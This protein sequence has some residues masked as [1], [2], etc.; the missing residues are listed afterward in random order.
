MC[1]YCGCRHCSF[2]YFRLFFKHNGNKKKTSRDSVTRILVEEAPLQ[3]PG[4]NL[5]DYLGKGKRSLADGLLMSALF[6]GLVVTNILKYICTMSYIK[7]ETRLATR[8]G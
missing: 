4:G 7:L 1:H 6:V 5:G 8:L 3:R 2:T